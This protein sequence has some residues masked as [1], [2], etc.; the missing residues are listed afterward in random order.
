MSS[1]PGPSLEHFL[2]WNYSLIVDGDGSANPSLMIAEAT[3]VKTRRR[4]LTGAQ[5][6][7]LVQLFEPYRFDVERQLDRYN[8]EDHGSWRDYGGTAFDFV[9]DEVYQ[10]GLALLDAD[11]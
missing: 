7:P 8:E 4:Q 5:F 6:A 1:W 10:R 3:G 2:M 9:P 11:T